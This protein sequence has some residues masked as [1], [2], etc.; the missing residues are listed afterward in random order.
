MDRA[1]MNGTGADRTATDRMGADRNIAH[2]RDSDETL[3][4]RRP[5]TGKNATV[6]TMEALG[7]D[8][9]G[10]KTG[11]IE[12]D[13]STEA[14]GVDTDTVTEHAVATQH[15]TAQ[16]C[17]ARRIATRT[18][19]AEE[20]SAMRKAT[21]WAE[22]GGMGFSRIA[23]S[24]PPNV[25]ADMDRHV[26]RAIEAGHDVI[27]LSKGSPD[28]FPTDDVRRIAK[29][30]VD[31]PA[32]ARYT[33]FD[34]K[35]AFLKAAAHWYERDHG[36]SLDPGSEL[37]AILGAVD[38][39]ATLFAILLDP[40]DAVAFADPYYPSYHCMA[41]ILAA[42]EV[43]LPAREDLGWLPDLDAVPDGTWDDL[44]VLVLNYPNN[45]TGA[46]A[47]LSFFEQAVALAK[48][49]RFAIVHDYAYAD[50]G[51]DWQQPSFLSVRGARDVGIE[52]CS[53][54]KMYAMA[55]WRGGFIAGNADIV[56]HA[57]RYH[58]Q[59]G[60][61]VAGM[62]QDAGA[63][64]LT[65]GRDSVAALAR[66]YALRRSIVTDGLRAAGLE[67]FDSLGG[68]YVWAK[69]PSGS[70]GDRFSQVLL[71]K[72]DVAVLSGSCF[73]TAGADH[74]RLSLLKDEDTLRR[75]VA[76]IHD[77]WHELAMA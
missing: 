50:L 33:P 11:D 44:R 27:D 28:A 65:H 13:R 15:G 34:G 77:H 17:T 59:M 36:V 72:A 61:M 1:G 8:D 76:R 12:A 20:T 62:V 67:V 60:S 40:G 46:Q 73:G 55:G 7:M 54:S 5:A 25:F 21:A 35:P 31:D 9:A 3:A 64:A 42:R 45:P 49:H 24:I 53:L 52:V 66:R 68:I 63:M 32:N 41:S 69:A 23:R 70:D 22:S 57:K 71:D 29:S 75:A 56:S 47:P 26:E 10:F 19:V 30:A 6:G 18:A 38:G 16:Q 4:G 39:L 58:Y 14:S 48:E 2:S 43:L 74:I 51:V 37:F